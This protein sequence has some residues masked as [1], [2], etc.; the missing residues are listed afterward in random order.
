MRCQFLIH[1]RTSKFRR[2]DLRHD[3]GCRTLRVKSVHDLIVLLKT[4]FEFPSFDGL[5]H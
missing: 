1:R 5:F 3:A 2:S 4:L